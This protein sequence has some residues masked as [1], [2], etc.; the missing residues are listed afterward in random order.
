MTG[1]AMAVFAAC[2]AN[3]YLGLGITGGNSRQVLALSILALGVTVFF[4]LPNAEEE[5]V[6]QGRF[7]TFVD[8][9]LHRRK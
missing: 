1:I 3:H 5:R 6:I 4:C 8:R 2:L 9:L 7:L